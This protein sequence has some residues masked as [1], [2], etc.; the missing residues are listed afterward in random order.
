MSKMTQL[1]WQ[2]SSDHVLPVRKAG[3]ENLAEA[4]QE[5]AWGVPAVPRAPF[6]SPV[7]FLPEQPRALSPGQMEVMCFICVHPASGPRVGPQLWG[8]RA[9]TLVVASTALA[10]ST[11]TLHLGC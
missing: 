7:V 9:G 4:E 3:Q 2:R 11:Q 8:G 10:G 6:Q 5:K 1:A